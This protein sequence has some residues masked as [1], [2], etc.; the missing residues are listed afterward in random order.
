MPL[1]AWLFLQTRADWA[2]AAGCYLKVTSIPHGWLNY[3]G[4]EPRLRFR[5]HLTEYVVANNLPLL[6]MYPSQSAIELTSRP[7]CS[8]TDTGHWQIF[9]AWVIFSMGM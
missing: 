7:C 5:N 6:R 1:C 4:L 9:Q 3:S 2:E 8:G